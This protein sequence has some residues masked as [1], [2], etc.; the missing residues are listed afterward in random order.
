MKARKILES[1]EDTNAI[2]HFYIYPG[3]LFK[4]RIDQI[5]G[6]PLDD[7]AD[8]LLILQDFVSQANLTTM[9]QPEIICVDLESDITYYMWKIED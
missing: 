3:K 4:D 5:Q 6:E 7:D 8:Y 1:L 2:H 9:N